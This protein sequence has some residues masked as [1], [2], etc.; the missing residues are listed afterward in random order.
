VI[1]V[2]ERQ[3]DVTVQRRLVQRD[4]TRGQLDGD[5]YARAD[6]GFNLHLTGWLNGDFDFSGGNP[7]GDDYALIDGAFN[8]QGSIL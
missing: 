3:A 5:D 4:G 1:L 7:D 6:N 8:T 2:A